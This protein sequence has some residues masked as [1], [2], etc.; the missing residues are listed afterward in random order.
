MHGPLVSSLLVGTNC[1]TAP[2][3]RVYYAAAPSWKA[4][5]AY[6]A[7]GLNWII[8]QNKNLPASQKIRVVSVSASPNQTSW[9]NR[10]MWDRACSQAESE[11]ILVLDCTNS[12]RGFIGRCWYNPNNP[13]NI[14]WCTPGVP[15]QSSGSN[16]EGL[17]V[18]S[19]PR[20]AAED[21]D[22]PG[23]QYAGRGGLSRSIPYCA[24]VLAM[25]WQVR[26]EL[27]GEQIKRILFNTAYTNKEGA[28]IINPVRFIQYLL[29]PR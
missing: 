11:G 25:G 23:Y 18:P 6:Y 20:T 9:K 27:R 8:E 15:G 17:L 19:S 28:K 22:V 4:D 29:K 13:D 24:G 16:T 21:G 12:H 3:A 1:G 2:D 26:P 10:Q 7:K 5:A 14:S